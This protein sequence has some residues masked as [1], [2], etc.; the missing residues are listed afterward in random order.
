MVIPDNLWADDW[1]TDVFRPDLEHMIYFKTDV[2]RPWV[3]KQWDIFVDNPHFGDGKPG[4]SLAL[5]F[6]IH[7]PVL[8]KPLFNCY[9]YQAKFLSSVKIS[10]FFTSFGTVQGRVAVVKQDLY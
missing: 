7:I 10:S 9:C 1:K 3:L 6:F 2:S 5:I 4:V 8:N